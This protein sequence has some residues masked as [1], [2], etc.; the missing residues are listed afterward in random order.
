MS[1]W[2]VLGA[3][4][5]AFFALMVLLAWPLAR[6]IDGVMAGRFTAGRRIEAPLYR[7]AGVEAQAE[8]P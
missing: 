6:W 3:V 4:L 5:T 1:A 7:R 2:H 8:T